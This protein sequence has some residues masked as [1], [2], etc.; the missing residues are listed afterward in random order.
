[1]LKSAQDGRFRWHGL[2]W[3][4]T[5]LLW[6]R[7][8]WISWSVRS[9]LERLKLSLRFCTRDACAS[10][11]LCHCSPSFDCIGVS[12]VVPSL[13][14][15]SGGRSCP[16]RMQVGW[17]CTVSLKVWRSWWPTY[18]L[19]WGWHCPLSSRRLRTVMYEVDRQSWDVGVRRLIAPLVFLLLSGKILYRSLLEAL[20]TAPPWILYHCR[21][22]L[23]AGEGS[24]RANRG[25]IALHKWW[26]G[27][28]HH[29]YCTKTVCKYIAY[30]KSKVMCSDKRD[31]QP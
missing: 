26:E 6:E 22:L 5:V 13:P 1:M 3:F 29:F 10:C 30:K 18:M 14:W 2:R 23:N 21:A 8:A 7:R 25:Q 11:F 28:K 15:F 20:G 9:W 31:N 4:R 27:R 19:G 12:W 16:C 24:G 17:G